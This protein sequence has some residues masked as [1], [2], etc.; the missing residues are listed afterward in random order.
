MYQKQKDQ[1]NFQML[2]SLLVVAL[3]AALTACTKSSP[4]DEEEN[5]SQ[6]EGTLVSLSIKTMP[7]KIGYFINEEFSKAGL[8]VEGK[9]DNGKTYPIPADKLTLSG[10]DSSK[11][12]LQQTVVIG[13]ETQ[14]VPLTIAVYPYKANEGGE[15]TE[16][17]ENETS[18]VIPAGVTKIGA[19]TFIGRKLTEIIFPETLQEI[20]KYA[21]FS[22]KSLQRVVFPASLRLLGNGAFDN[23][24]ALVSA[25]LSATG[26]T[27]INEYLFNRCPKLAEVTLPAR[28]TRVGPLAFSEA[29]SLKQI[30]LPEGVR[31]IGIEAFSESGLER[32]NLPNNVKMIRQRAFNLCDDLTE[33]TTYGSYTPVADDIPSVI[34][35]SAFQ[36]MLVLRRLAIPQ[37][38][39][40][41]EENVAFG[42]P[43]LTEVTLPASM[44]KIKY[45]AFYHTGV[46]R[47][48]ILGS[49]PADVV[50]VG[51]GPVWDAFPSTVT[52][53]QVPAASLMNYQRAQGWRTYD[54]RMV[55]R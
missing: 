24:T 10:F 28:I 19:S 48:V 49:T 33:V 36:D 41:L 6:A 7:T 26:L 16:Y 25:D 30:V 45:H 50:T 32:I 8:V 44:R 38:V 2:R 34:E 23:C 51:G 47:V 52:S 20:G 46:T 42:C 3:I 15:I 43:A 39:T 21:F 55:G 14:T 5:F 22:C 29:K 17:V 18:V 12:T 9:Y 35:Y 37:G 27:E 31:F 4:M 1:R 11:S 13:F 40:S 53:I 54:S